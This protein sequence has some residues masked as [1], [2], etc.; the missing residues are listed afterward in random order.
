MNND[1]KEKGIINNNQANLKQG[2]LK[3]VN[4]KNK[5][6]I[7][8]LLLLLD[9]QN[10]GQINNNLDIISNNSSDTSNSNPSGSD[11]D[12]DVTEVKENYDVDVNITFERDTVDLLKVNP[13]ED[14]D[15]YINKLKLKYK[16]MKANK[17]MNSYTKLSNHQSNSE[18][19]EELK[20]GDNNENIMKNEV[21]LE[22]EILSKIIYF[23]LFNK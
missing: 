12:S 22:N 14:I 3:F 6:L 20:Y 10:D 4:S 7:N 15:K 17:I 5:I 16:N 1:S 2:H 11:N 21:L 13:M 19:T 18:A 8:L 23:L 9:S